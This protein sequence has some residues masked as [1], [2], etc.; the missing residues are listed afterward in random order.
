M[1]PFRSWNRSEFFRDPIAA[2]PDT[3]AFTTAYS[4]GVR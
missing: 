4:R 2:D 1:H 3:L